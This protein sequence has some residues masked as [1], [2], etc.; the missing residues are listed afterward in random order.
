[1]L[2]GEFARTDGD[3]LDLDALLDMGA[4]GIVGVLV[5]EDALAAE[6]VDEGGPAWVSRDVRYAVD[7]QER[8]DLPVPE[9]P[10][11]IRQ[12]WM[13]FLTFFFLR[14]IFCKGE[15]GQQSRSSGEG[16]TRER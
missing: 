7:W 14:I 10:H 1:M 5:G 13:P 4:V 16:A 12:N 2:G 9:A 3:G 15:A 11:T 8:K 6:G